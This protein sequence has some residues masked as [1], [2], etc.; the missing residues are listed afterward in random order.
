[1]TPDFNAVQSSIRRHLI[2]GTGTVAFL[3]LCVGGWAATTE[4]AGA[5]V[6][7]AS[8]VVDTNAKKVQHPTGGVVGEL[9]V[10]DGQR[11]KAGDTLIR[12]DET[13]TRANLAVVTKSL[14]ELAARRTRLEAERD[15]LSSLSFPDELLARLSD[16][17][18]ARVVRGEQRLF[19]TRQSARAGQ[20]SQL[21][22]R[23]LQLR[24]QING[25]EEQIIAK[26]RE[27]EFIGQELKGV[28]E[29]WQ[30]N[31]VQITRVTALERDAARIDGERGALVSTVA[32][33][34]GK[35]TETELQI[36]QIEQDMRTE[37]GKELA[38]IRAK[39]SELVERKVSAEDQLKRI[40]IRAPQDGIVHQL[41]TH[42]V[43][44][45][46]SPGEQMMLIVPEN[47][48][49]AVEARIEPQKIDQLH[50][51]QTANLRFSA[52]NQQT[53]PEI[54][55][56]VTR[57]SADLTQDQKTGV[58]YYTVR[59]S[60][61]PDELIKLGAQKLIPGMPVEAFVQTADRTVLSYLLKPLTDRS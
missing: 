19:E 43:G 46:V 20:V 35:I 39:N 8:L 45:V 14:D 54:A 11:V 27:V 23:V 28:R 58:S 57:I 2:C 42:T 15:G 34:R 44:G 48:D 3:A 32:Q 38:D 26:K 60:L 40:D 10:R 41:A 25:T 61:R 21:R 33:L 59:I 1:M 29:L 13:Q 17:E 56:K 24:Q 50:L 47:D 53:T 18:V 22:E 36:I 55:G 6:A 12:L 49:L 31:L 5:V 4:I 7:P 37:V 16:P 51:G 9:R 52:F 30:K